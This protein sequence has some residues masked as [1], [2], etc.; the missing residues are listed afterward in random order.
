MYGGSGYSRLTALREAPLEPRLRRVESMDT[1]RAGALHKLHEDGNSIC[2]GTI[3][4]PGY[5]AMAFYMLRWRLQQSIFPMEAASRRNSSSIIAI[6]AI[7][8]DLAALCGTISH[9][10]A[11]L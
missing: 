2:H 10:E 7:Y 1:G 11:E 6:A 5:A 8:A 3:E 4:A 9:D